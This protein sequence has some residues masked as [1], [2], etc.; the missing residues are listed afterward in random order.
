MKMES[1]C[2]GWSALWNNVLYL[3]LCDVKTMRLEMLADSLFV[4]SK[5]HQIYCH[6]PLMFDMEKMREAFHHLSIPTS[7]LSLTA[8]AR[9]AEQLLLS[10]TRSGS[11]PASSS[12]KGHNDKSE[13]M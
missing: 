2:D 1:E 8:A 10:F 7:V 6:F 5:N 4:S 12:S 11:A 9:R 13:G 3:A